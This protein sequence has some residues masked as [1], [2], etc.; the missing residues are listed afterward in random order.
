MWR[1]QRLS[2]KVANE[3]LV[4]SVWQHIPAAL[5]RH[6]KANLLETVGPCYIVHGHGHGQH[7]HEHMHAKMC[8]GV[9]TQVVCR[10]LL[11][12]V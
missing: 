11:G 1:G 9:C 6:W 2:A 3:G 12:S 8:T 10:N 7:K 4:G 5:T